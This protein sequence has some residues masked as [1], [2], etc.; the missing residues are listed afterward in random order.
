MDTST[1]RIYTPEEMKEMQ[2]VALVGPNLHE[3]QMGR[4]IPMAVSP[5]PKQM[6]KKPPKVGRNELCPCG[7]GKK[8]KKCHLNPPGNLRKVEVFREGDWRQVRLIDVHKGETFRMF[9]GG[10]PVKDREGRVEWVAATNGFVGGR[11]VA[12]IEVEIPKKKPEPESVSKEAQIEIS[13]GHNL[14]SITG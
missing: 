2:K 4:M 3:R 8:F 5:T 7:S 14:D 12:T 11:G 13:R 10:M 6:A 9:E 1:G